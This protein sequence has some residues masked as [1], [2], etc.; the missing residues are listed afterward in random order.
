MVK[1]LI[2][3]MNKEKIKALWK[4]CFD[5]SEEF[6]ELYFNLR[7]DPRINVAM[8][9]G[10]DVIA[11]MQLLPYPMT[12]GGTEI[13]DGGRHHERIRLRQRPL[14]GGEHVACGDDGHERREPCGLFQRDGSRNERHGMP[15]V[16]RRLRNGIPHFAGGAIAEEA[17]GIDEFAGGSGSDEETHGWLGA[18]K[19]GGEKRNPRH[20][21][22]DG[23]GLMKWLRWLD[24]NQRPRD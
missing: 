22:P 15:G 14:H 20:P 12:F 9:S 23:G 13:G 10:E 7:Y 18:G 6:T 21:E 2:H 19:N 16:A 4:L 5:D 17:D 3:A 24:S 1:P 11:A 8:Q